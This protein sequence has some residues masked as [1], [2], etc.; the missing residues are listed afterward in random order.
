MVV[1]KTAIL[2]KNHEAVTADIHHFPMKS[3]T[4]L[5]WFDYC[6]LVPCWE[7]FFETVKEKVNKN[8]TFFV[9]FGALP[10]AV[11]LARPKWKRENKIFS[12]ATPDALANEL[13]RLAAKKCRAMGWVPFY[14]V[15][16]TVRGGKM[17]TMGFRRAKFSRELGMVKLIEI[18]N[19]TPSTPKKKTDFDATYGK[20]VEAIQ[21]LAGVDTGLIKKFFG[22]S[23]NIAGLRRA[24]TVRR[25]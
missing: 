10:R 13:F 3:G 2:D 16:Y 17:I 15:K 5:I 23:A 21:V 20:M 22:T 4:K 11:A 18:E 9:T 25:A 12:Q 8:S 19:E 14:G 6:S 24:A 1:L 7:S